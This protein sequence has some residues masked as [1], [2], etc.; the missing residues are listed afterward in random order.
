MPSVATLY[1]IATTVIFGYT[2]SEHLSQEDTYF[3]A[4]MTYLADQSCVF[5]LY[6]MILSLAI[7]FY[8]LLSWVF[9]VNTMEG[10]VIVRVSYSENY[11]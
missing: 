6:N 3:K 7:M 4:M 9:F 2:V 5:V 8:R 10:E 11:G 1:V